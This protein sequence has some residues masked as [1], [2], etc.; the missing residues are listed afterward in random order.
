M[1]EFEHRIAGI[2]CIIR[3]LHAEPFRAG[4]FSG[5]PEHCYPDEGGLIVWEVLDRKGRRAPWLERKADE[6]EMRRIEEAAWAV[7]EQ[8]ATEAHDDYLINQY[9]SSR[10]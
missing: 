4:F 3:I 8:E 9:E 5:P 2:P 10:S 7:L 6:K 1:T